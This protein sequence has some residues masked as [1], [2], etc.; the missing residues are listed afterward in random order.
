MKQSFQF[1]QM[2]QSGQGGSSG[3]GVGT[4]P[5]GVT[6]SESQGMAGDPN[7]MNGS[8]SLMDTGT[9]QFDQFYDSQDLA[10]GAHDEQVHGQFNQAAP[11]SK[12]EEVKSAPET[13]QALREFVTTVGADNIGDQ[14]AIDTQNIP[15][16]YKDLHRKYF[17]NLKKASEE[18]KAAEEKAGKQPFEEKQEEKPAKPSGD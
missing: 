8:D 9:T 17:D 14:Q 6:G 16:D 4:T 2:A 13:Q 3:W 5:Y 18:K 15:R 1:G 7:R 11:P 12:V 10:H